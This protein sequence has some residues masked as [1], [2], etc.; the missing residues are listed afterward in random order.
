VS[1]LINPTFWLSIAACVVAVAPPALRGRTLAALLKVATAWPVL[2]LIGA[3]A[4]ANVGARVLVGLAVPG[5]FVQEVVAARSFQS[6]GTLF[7]GDI[8]GSVEQ[9]LRSEPPPIPSWV[10]DGIE[11][12]LRHRQTLGPNRLVAQAH[13]P[14]LLLAV[15]PLIS[16]LGA[17]GAYTLLTLMSIAAAA[18][19][20]HLLLSAWYPEASSA[21]WWLAALALVSWQPVLASIR[22]GQ[23]SIIVGALLVA[24]WSA[25]RTGRPARGGALVGIASIVKLYPAVLLVLLAVRRRTGLAV[26]VSLMMGAAAFVTAIAGVRVWGEYLAAAHTIGHAFARSSHNLSILAR[27][28]AFT[29]GDWLPFWY[30]GVAAG[31]VAVTLWVVGSDKWTQS[32]SWVCVAL[33]V[34]GFGLPD[35]V[36]RQLWAAVDPGSM[37]VALLSPGMVVLL[38]WASLIYLRCTC[39]AGAAGARFTKAV[40]ASV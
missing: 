18:V 8:N 10:P 3:L 34:I 35:D 16:L 7:A 22:D 25:A 38:L 27:L 17:Y 36:I 37:A 33:A 2:T 4:L 21:E 23:V 31:L 13:P 39:A 6:D 19:T 14:T 40:P 20:S 28:G 5:D 24:A 11:R 1:A 26:A 30:A 9:W 29:A 32:G 12:Y 15:A